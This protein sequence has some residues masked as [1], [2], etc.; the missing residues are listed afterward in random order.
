MTH[1]TEQMELMLSYTRH[2]PLDGTNVPEDFLLT[3]LGTKA[4]SR[5]TLVLQEGHVSELLLR[6]SSMTELV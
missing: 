5:L 4:A 3:L 1:W 2:N 6:L